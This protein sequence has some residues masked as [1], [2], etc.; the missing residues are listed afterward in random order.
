MIKKILKENPDFYILF[1]NV[2]AVVYVVGTEH[3]PKKMVFFLIGIFLMM[4]I[5]GLLTLWKKN[6]LFTFFRNL[7][8]S[9]LFFMLLILLA[10]GL[11]VAFPSMYPRFILNLTESGA[12]KQMKDKVVELLDESPFAKPKPNILIHVPGDYGSSTDFEYEW[13]TDNRGYKNDPELANK[14]QFDVIALG[15]SFTEGMG[16]KTQDTWVSKLNTLGISAYSLGVQGY[17]P[18]QMSGTFRLF[19]SELHPKLVIIGYLTSTYDRET[20][21]MKDEKEVTGEKKLP[22]AIGRL[23]DSYPGNNR[24]YR[25]QFKFIATSALFPIVDR[26]VYLY[27]SNIDP[28]YSKDPRFIQDRFLVADEDI[29]IG[30]M[31][32]YKKEMQDTLDAVS[33][34]ESIE[35]SPEW[36]KTLSSFKEIVE[37]AKRQGAKTMLLIFHNRGPIYITKATG[38]NL[39]DNYQGYIE[40][41]LL[42]EFAVDNELFFLDT[43]TVLKDYIKTFAD[44]TDISKYPYLK[45][46]GH[47]SK[48]GNEIIAKLVAEY[49]SQRVL[50]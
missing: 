17:A 8:V 2:L 12:Q 1:F 27:R 40:R 15:D 48:E 35:S 18:S 37:G 41:E 19:D 3:I 24:E 44:D 50:K 9:I 7:Q 23:A 22:S 16:V 5:A 45:Y 4:C 29:S 20:L 32:R 13:I 25:N 6:S 38:K 33:R 28:L 26:L 43:E 47:L 31:Q 36:K 34:K 30:N 46:D 11:Y 49:I 42:R 10:Q 14:N 39:S 21:L